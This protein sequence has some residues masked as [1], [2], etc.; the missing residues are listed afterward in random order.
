M[1]RSQ[2]HRAGLSRTGVLANYA[3]V[4]PQVTSR[5]VRSKAEGVGFEPTITVTRNTGFQDQRTRPLCEPSRRL[6]PRVEDSA[7]GLGRIGVRGAGGGRYRLGNG[8]SAA[9]GTDGGGS[10]VSV[11]RGHATHRPVSALKLG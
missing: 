5:F 10:N 7:G 9:E 3:C 6:P 4:F 8:G 2:A 11:V 1:S